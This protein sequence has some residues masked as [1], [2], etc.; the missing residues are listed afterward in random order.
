VRRLATAAAVLVALTFTGPALAGGVPVQLAATGHLLW[1]VSDSGL[2]AFDTRTRT[3]VVVRST[4][5]YP[6]TTR[7]AASGGSVWVASIANGYIS[8]AVSRIDARTHRA[9][10][11]L[12]LAHQPVW[13][14]CAGGGL[15]W[16]LYGPGSNTRLARFGRPGH[17]HFIALHTRTNWCAADEFGVWITTA[18]GRL[19]H[20]DPSGDA[21]ATVAHIRGAFTLEAG[22]GS[23]WVAA[24]M[25]VVRYDERSHRVLSFATGSTVGALSIG[26]AR[27]WVLTANRRGQSTLLRLNPITGRIQARRR[28]TGS[29][30]DVRES[31][32][33]VWLGGLDARRTPT[34]WTIE[35]D[36]LK[37]RRVASLA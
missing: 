14:V 33:H 30:M 15:V 3:R 13:D 19:L 8:G 36:T 4:T 35:P 31:E 6:Y 21:V 37:E 24:G 5:P 34:L 12:R 20:V 10:T 32:A 28:L 29:P 26:A 2:T 18:D 27:I 22:G 16:A 1:A 25:R 9:R 11:M 23:V 7:L 17:P